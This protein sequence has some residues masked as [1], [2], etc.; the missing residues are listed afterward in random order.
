[1]ITVMYT[2]FIL[3]CLFIPSTFFFTEDNIGDLQSQCLL[4]SFISSM[5]ESTSFQPSSSECFTKTKTN[6]ELADESV[7]APCAMCGL[8]GTP[9]NKNNSW[10]IVP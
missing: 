2:C 7:A 6:T 1:M 8:F 3:K 9:K 4:F 5:T 10:G